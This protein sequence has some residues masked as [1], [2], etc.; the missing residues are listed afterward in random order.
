[1]TELQFELDSA[2]EVMHDELSEQFG[3]EL[4]D[5]DLKEALTARLTQVYDNREQLAQAQQRQQ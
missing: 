5:E 2:R 4:I 1:M 3:E